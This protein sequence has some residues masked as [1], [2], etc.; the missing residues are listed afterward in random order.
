MG[1]EIRVE[2]EQHGLAHLSRTGDEVH[3]CKEGVEVA[4]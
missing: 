4:L 3:E 1:S 2:D